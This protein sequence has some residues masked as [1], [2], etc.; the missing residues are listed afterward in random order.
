MSMMLGK[1]NAALTSFEVQNQTITPTT[2]QLSRRA[3]NR[4]A[5]AYRFREKLSINY[6]FNYFADSVYQNLRYMVDNR[7]SLREG[8]FCLPIPYSESSTKCILNPLK[9]TH[10]AYYVQ[11]TSKPW[12]LAWAALALNEL[13]DAQYGYINVYDTNYVNIVASATNYRAFILEF[14]LTEFLAAFSYKELRRLTL[15]VNG[16]NSSPVRFFVYAP[17]S[18]TWYNIDDRV[19]SNSGD[20]DLPSGSGA[21]SLH[22]QLVAQLGCP[23]S[24]DSLYDDFVNSSTK[25]VTFM[26]AGGNLNQSLMMQYVR[27]FVN[28]LWVYPT[29]DTNLEN[30]ATAF[31]GAGRSGVLALEEV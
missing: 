20:F 5:S 1:S 26:V 24:Y 30:Y 14:D 21:F 31:T 28:G 25:K 12:T 13:T 22:K 9:S 8:L 27:L 7:N 6:E 11:P 2:G 17:L 15:Q 29:D 19:Y 4:S 23:W 3:V 18:D 16:M 10:P